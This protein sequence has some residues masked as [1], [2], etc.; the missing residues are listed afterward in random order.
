M[1][2]DEKARAKRKKRG[3]KRETE[4]SERSKDYSLMLIEIVDGLGW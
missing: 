2:E 1:S 4:D 3:T